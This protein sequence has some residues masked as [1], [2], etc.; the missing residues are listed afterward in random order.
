MNCKIC[1]AP[2]PEGQDFCEAH[3]SLPVVTAKGKEAVPP[4]SKKGIIAFVFGLGSLIPTLAG[5]IMSGMAVAFLAALRNGTPVVPLD[6]CRLL[7]LFG[8]LCTQCSMAM[9]VLSVVL[10]IGAIRCF[11]RARI[12]KA[13]LFAKKK[14]S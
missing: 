13:R 11:A 12:C 1:G 6:G 3:A 7:A 14:S 2:V 10:G 5:Y 4:S 9:I 8:F